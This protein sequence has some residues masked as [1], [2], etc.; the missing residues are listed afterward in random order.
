M[1]RRRRFHVGLVLSGVVVVLAGFTVAIVEVLHYPKASIWFVI[2]A[3]VLAVA[4][5]RWLTHR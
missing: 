3:T 1:A 5:I 4:L 2:A